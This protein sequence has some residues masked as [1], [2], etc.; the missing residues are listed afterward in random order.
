MRVH[1]SIGVESLDRSIAFY[2]AML[3]SEPSKLKPGYA[4]FRFDEPPIHLALTESK[5]GANATED[6]SG[7]NHLGVELPDHATLS[8]WNSRLDAADIDFVV[9]DKARCCYATADKIWLIDPDGHKWEIWVRTGEIEEM[10]AT[11]ISSVSDK[12]QAS[13]CCA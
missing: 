6:K 1:I 4:N 9:E 2:S 11:R 12:T 8:E 13:S 7:V 10:G 3:G 5:S